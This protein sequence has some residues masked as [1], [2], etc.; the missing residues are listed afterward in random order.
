M[1]L[2][3]D[4]NRGLNLCWN[5]DF[6][7]DSDQRSWCLTVR[8]IHL[9][10]SYVFQLCSLLGPEVIGKDRYR[11]S[12]LQ[13][14]HFIAGTNS[15]CKVFTKIVP[16]NHWNRKEVASGKAHQYV[17]RVDCSARMIVTRSFNGSLFASQTS[18]R[19]PSLTQ[20]V[21]EA[22]GTFSSNVGL[23]SIDHDRHNY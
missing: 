2:C 14:N 16:Q 18:G 17:I 19:C 22:R 6:C 5:I 23:L 13:F 11:C 9:R 12:V 15:L 7:R 3:V 8:V 1:K 20:F 21:D 4:Q 10:V